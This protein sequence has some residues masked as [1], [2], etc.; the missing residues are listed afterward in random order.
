MIMKKFW[1]LVTTAVI[2]S[3]FTF[4]FFNEKKKESLPIVAIANYGPLKDLELSIQGIKNELSDNGF[5]DGQTIKIE[6]ADIACDL[7]LIPQIIAKLK[8][9]NPMVMVLVSTPIA[10]FAREKIRD[11]PL[12]Y[13]AVT[14]PVAAGLIDGSRPGNNITGSS[15]M[16]DLGILLKFVKTIFPNAKAIGLPYLTAESNDTALL[17]MMERAA[18]DF[19]LSVV[20]IPVDQ[21]RDV[22]I[23]MQGVSGKVDCIYVGAGGLLAAMP[24]IAAEAQKMGVPVFGAEDLAVRDGLA[25]ASYGVNTESVGRNAGKLV[26][27]LLSGI[28]I[29]MLAPICPKS[30]DHMCVVNKKLAK[31]FGIRIPKNATLVE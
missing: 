9:C 22:S 3:A 17:K 26:A 20:P 24:A 5:V 7:S 15:D 14:D 29:K 1:W 2:A 21:M 12:V 11:I 23:R 6:I 25:L 28:D 16:Q 4:V 10:Q 27:K 30:T 19:G 13:D 8:N 31:K 18:P